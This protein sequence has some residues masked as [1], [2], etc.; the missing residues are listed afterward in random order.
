MD[1]LHLRSI[2]YFSS[3]SRRVLLLLLVSLCAS[4]MWATSDV[5]YR[6]ELT[7]GLRTFLDLEGEWRDSENKRVNV[8]FQDLEQHAL[9]VHKRFD[10]AG[11]SEMQ[12]TV[13]LYFEAIAWQS[14]IWLNGK[15]LTLTTD[16]FAE[17]LL[18]ILKSW[19]HPFGNQV[20]VRMSRSGAGFDHG[21]ARFLG[22]FRQVKLLEVDTLP[23][24]AKMP[25]EVYQASR[26]AVVAPWSLEAGFLYDTIALKRNL[27]GLFSYPYK[28]DPIRF[29]FPPSAQARAMV[30]KMGLKVLVAEGEADSLCFY[31][32]YPT[33]LQAGD[34]SAR[35][36]RSPDGKPT[37]AYGHFISKQALGEKILRKP[38]KA[39]LFLLLLLPVLAFLMLKLTAPRQYANIPE[40]LTK[41][42]VYLELIASSKFLKDELRL[43]INLMRML[44]TAVFVSLYIYY[45]DLSGDWSQ[46]NII[47]PASFLFHYFEGSSPSLY[48]I[49]ALVLVTIVVL[50]LL[51]Y[52]VLNISG[53]I[54][55]VYSLSG[56]VQNLDIFVAFPLNILPLLPGAIIFFVEGTAGTV[57]L[58]VWHGLIVL[59]LIR[60]FVLIFGGLTKLFQFSTGLKFLYICTLEIAPWVF[61]I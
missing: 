51:K 19:L 41:T 21:P 37:E 50:N 22:I 60:R 47:S 36:W 54:F 40:Y 43:G 5:F 29:A 27:Q 52:L 49:F 31:N 59:Y 6:T 61:L 39:A 20:E 15:L 1:F 28:D 44:F 17:Q 58:H 45:I 11:Y 55:R 2:S 26:A 34:F 23:V 9:R 14:E 7:G 53:R 57:I 4:G 8:P 38:D 56:M 33:D 12:D 3:L 13:Y 46:L 16:P 32:A 18:P 35:F 10:L 30:Q 42:R 24:F 25:R 48:W